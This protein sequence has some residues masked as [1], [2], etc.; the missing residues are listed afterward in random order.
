[1]N[2]HVAIDAADACALVGDATRARRRYERLS[3]YAHL[4]PTVARAIGCQGSAE[5]FVGRL[6]LTAGE[7]DL[8]VDHL[9]RAADVNDRAGARPNAAFAR[10]LLA[11]ALDARAGADDGEL[12]F[13]LRA[14]AEQERLVLGMGPFVPSP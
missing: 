12:A 14:V 1:M 2:W 4:F 8:A 6:A 10:W 9:Q 13:T 7:L 11:D 3:P 5:L